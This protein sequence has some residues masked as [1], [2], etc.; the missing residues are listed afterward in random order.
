MR[1]PIVHG[2]IDNYGPRSAFQY[3][4]TVWFFYLLLL[5]TYDEQLA[6]V[7][8]IATKSI[9]F[10]AMA[11]SLSITLRT[12]AGRWPISSRALSAILSVSTCEKAII[13]RSSG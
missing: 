3:V 1:G 2:R 9:L 5:W 13:S 10:S 8:S 4:T 6:G 12:S 7:Y 11:G